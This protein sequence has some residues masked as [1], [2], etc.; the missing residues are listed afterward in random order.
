MRG[1]V[2]AK[3]VAL[4]LVGESLLFEIGKGKSDRRNRWFHRK[5]GEMFFS[6][7]W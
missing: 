2:L 6:F 1:I 4:F 7:I 5:C 3:T